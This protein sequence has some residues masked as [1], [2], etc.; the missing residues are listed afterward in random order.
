MNEKVISRRTFLSSAFLAGSGLAAAALVGCGDNDEPAASPGSPTATSGAATATPPPTPSAPRWQRRNPS[1]AVPPPRRDHSLVTDGQRLYLFAGRDSSPLGDFWSYDINADS[2]TEVTAPGPPARFGHN[3]G[4][5]ATAGRVLIFGGQAS[6]FYNDIWAYTPTAGTWQQSPAA[7]AAPSPRYGAAS[8]L[9]SSEPLLVSHG[10]TD[11]GRFDD[12]WSYSAGT[13]DDLSPEEGPRP[14][15]RCLTRAVVDAS[16]GAFIM[17]G[18]Q[19]NA[20]PYLG[21][22]WKLTPQFS[23]PGG[24]WTEVT[25]DPKPQ[26]RN[27]FSMAWDEERRRALVFGGMTADGR[28]NDIWAFDASTDSWSTLSIEGEAPSPR[29]GHDAVWLPGRRSMLVFGGEDDS[30]DQNDLWELA[31]DG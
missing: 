20:A 18:G 6:G 10:F 5:L 26:P 19:T 1:G 3:A 23:E 11:S 24:T 29:N 21:D 13:W 22:T 30:G 8:A 27:L 4:F 7:A 2:W 31:F 9:G 14:I 16:S 17:F 12:T 28:V 15:E 25:S